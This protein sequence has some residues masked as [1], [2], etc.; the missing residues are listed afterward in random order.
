MRRDVKRV[1]RAAGRYAEGDLDEIVR[2]VIE[3]ARRRQS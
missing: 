3:V 2:Q 1:L